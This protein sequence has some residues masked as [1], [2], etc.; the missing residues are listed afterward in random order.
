MK[1]PTGFAWARQP[2][3]R[4][5]RNE[6][7]D[8]P[9]ACGRPSSGRSRLGNGVETRASRDGER[10]SE[11]P[12]A[13]DNEMRV[14]LIA[15]GPFDYCIEYA[16]MLTDSCEVLLC[17][18]EKSLAGRA[19]IDPQVEIARFHWLRHRSPSSFVL[20]LRLLA[21]IRA[22]RPDIVHF[23]GENN[24]WLNLLPPLL[25][26]TPVVTTVHDIEYHPG[27]TESRRLPRVF[28]DRFIRQSDA[29]IVH[30]ENLRS[31]ALAKLPTPADR[32]FVF[33]HPPLTY[34]AR[35]ARRSKMA[36]TK[37]GLFRALFFGRIYEYKGLKYLIEAAQ[38]ALPRLPSL[39]VVVAGRGDDP[40]KGGVSISAPEIFDLRNRFI[41][42]LELAQLLT[43]A[44]VVVLPY[45]EASQSGVLMVALAFGLP[46]IATDVGE[47]AN[48]VRMTGAGMVIP[49]RDSGALAD[50]LV[51]IG[52]NAPLRQSFAERAG[53]A[54][55]GPYSRKILAARA[56]DIY[57]M[58]IH[59]T[60]APQRSSCNAA[61]EM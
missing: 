51:E 10:L 15:T 25:G 4:V 34:Y 13:E 14:A 42:D 61:R 3:I 54:L 9:I 39:R 41:P 37:D 2:A 22:S 19:F 40:A 30:G 33:P 23:L 58:I 7:P 56:K 6:D 18:P 55:Q 43:D 11:G 16:E 17:V 49:P 53:E 21:R 12:K 35:L 36:Q 1:R 24:V 45:I 26:R 8:R 50:A 47:I 52:N 46:V 59:A 31:A 28:I 38:L 29:I 20:I 5:R 48:V 57:E 32:M 27:D 60:R 44:D